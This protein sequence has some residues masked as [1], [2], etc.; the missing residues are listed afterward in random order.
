M[1]TG[2]VYGTETE[3][4]QAQTEGLAAPIWPWELPP[5][6]I[7]VDGD[8]RGRYTGERIQEIADDL[9]WNGPITSADH[10]HYDDACN[11]AESFLSDL[12][13]DGY[14][15]GKIGE[16]TSFGMQQAPNGKG[17]EDGYPG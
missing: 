13:P 7:W 2:T 10:E 16:S 12:A 3:L 15:I 8:L 9:G 6:G 4:T 5:V 14:V 17:E 1:K 11:E